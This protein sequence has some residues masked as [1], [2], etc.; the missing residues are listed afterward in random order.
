MK[1]FKTLKTQVLANNALTAKS[2]NRR[3]QDSALTVK[4]PVAK[5]QRTTHP[6]SYNSNIIYRINTKYRNNL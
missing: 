4:E 2:T 1:T 3:A 6:T 5:G